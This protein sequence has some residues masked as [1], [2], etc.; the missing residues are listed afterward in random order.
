MSFVTAEEERRQ[1][2]EEKLPV[3]WV[4]CKDGDDNL[5]TGDMNVARGIAEKINP[6]YSV[7]SISF[8]E[9]AIKPDIIV[10]PTYINLCKNNI[11]R[12]SIIKDSFVLQPKISR[13]FKSLTAYPKIDLLA[14]PTCL[15]PDFLCDL[16]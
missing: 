16:L 8:L 4:I 6:C 10:F 3:V 11:L 14:F 12:T 2:K 9:S 7:H 15:M 13:N 1:P 5:P